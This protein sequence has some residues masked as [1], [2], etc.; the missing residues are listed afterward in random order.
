MPI[1]EFFC[2][3]C[4]QIFEELVRSINAIDEVVC[5]GC[6]NERVMKKLSTFTSK[7]A[8]ASSFSAGSAAPSCSPGGL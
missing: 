4:D 3:E 5:P 1:F 7:V 8:G 2:E 6:Q